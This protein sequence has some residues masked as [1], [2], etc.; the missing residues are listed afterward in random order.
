MGNNLKPKMT[1]TQLIEQLKSKGIK[2]ELFS[3]ADA[4]TFL[5]N[6][7]NYFKLTSYRKNFPKELNSDGELKYVNLDF[8]HLVELSRFDMHLRYLLLRMCLDIEHSIKVSY[9]KLIEDNGKSDGYDVVNEFIVS[10]YDTRTGKNKVIEDILKNVDNVYYLELMKKHNICRTSTSI[11]DFPI[12]AFI[13]VVSLGTFINFVAFYNEKYCVKEAGQVHLLNR[14]RQV[15][16]ASA[17]N[18]CM[19]NNLASSKNPYTLNPNIAIR[20]FLGNAG[21][22]NA[23]RESKLSNEVV[24]QICVVF[25]MHSKITASIPMKQNR[26]S[27]LSDLVEKIE[28]KSVIF[29][30]NDILKSSLDM[31]RLISDYLNKD[32]NKANSMT[33]SN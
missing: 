24:Y 30:R 31:L 5:G 28:E 18:T 16:N 22:G 27:E 9:L 1:S 15:R 11:C 17:H 2:F 10:M 23:M 33:S 26:Y 21:I 29:K 32:L 25:Y 8:A 14:V 7:N 13:E 4:I 19:L 12:W 6:N 3:E 20:R